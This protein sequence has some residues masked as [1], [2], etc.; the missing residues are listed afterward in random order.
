MCE[1][2]TRITSEKSWCIEGARGE[3]GIGQW[4]DENR[5]MHMGYTLCIWYELGFFS[6]G[7]GPVGRCIRY[8]PQR[9]VGRRVV[10]PVYSAMPLCGLPL[11]IE[12]VCAS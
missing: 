8:G 4:G 5:I 10:K 7:V 11:L 2:W 9:L 12:I 1:M 3:Q 6:L